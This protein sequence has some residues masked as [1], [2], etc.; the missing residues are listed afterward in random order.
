MNAAAWA[1]ARTFGPWLMVATLLAGG[2]WLKHDRDRYRDRDRAHAACVEAVEGR[3]A[4]TLDEVCAPPVAAAAA[5]AAR[6]RSCDAGLARASGDIAAGVP[7]TCAAPVKALAAQ[8]A[9]F[10]ARVEDLRGQLAVAAEETDSAIDRALARERAATLR[11]VNAE[12]A[13]E[14]APRDAGGLVV[15]DAGRLCQLAGCGPAAP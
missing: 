1:L 11:K 6:A 13:V 10:A 15:L 7:M 8:A 14:G 12:A 9:I 2:L 4:K 3:G 5:Q